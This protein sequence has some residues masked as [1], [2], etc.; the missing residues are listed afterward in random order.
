MIDTTRKKPLY[1]KVNTR[2]RGVHHNSGGE[3]LTPVCACCTH[4]FNSVSL[5]RK[6]EPPHW[7]S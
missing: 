4:S 1:R 2:A 7:L 3:D 6:Y 5:I